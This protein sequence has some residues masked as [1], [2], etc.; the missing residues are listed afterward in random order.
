VTVALSIA[1]A[2]LVGGTVFALIDARFNRAAKPAPAPAPQPRPR[3]EPPPPQP[4]IE[5]LPERR[6]EPFEAPSPLWSGWARD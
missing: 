6:T 1:F 5:P 3:Y 2:A 4:R